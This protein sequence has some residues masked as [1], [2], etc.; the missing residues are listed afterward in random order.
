VRGREG[1]RGEEEEG[2]RATTEVQSRGEES[3]SSRFSLKGRA[4]AD[5]FPQHPLHP[6]M[7]KPADAKQGRRGGGIPASQT[8]CEGAL[9]KKNRKRENRLHL[10]HGFFLR[11]RV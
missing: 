1:R 8:R 10:D 7:R 11:S 2:R 3:P 5:F 4:A 6:P 9:I